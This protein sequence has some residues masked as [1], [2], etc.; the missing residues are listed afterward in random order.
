ME[1]RIIL[2]VSG[3]PEAVAEQLR[4]AGVN[5]AQVLGEIG[6]VTGTVDADRRASLSD[7]AGVVAVENERSFQISP[8]DAEIQAVDPDS[9]S[10]VRLPPPDSE[11]Q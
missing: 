6:I 2:T 10:S 5:V 4:A 9:A 11:I 8:P 7:I 1:E 3:D